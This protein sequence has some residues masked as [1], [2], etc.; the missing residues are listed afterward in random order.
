MNQL[1]PRN[2]FFHWSSKRVESINPRSYI[3]EIDFKPNGFWFDVDKDWE[4][5]C[6]GDDWNLDGLKY[7]YRVQLKDTGNILVLNGTLDLRKFTE[8]YKASKY[9]GVPYS[10]IPMD[11]SWIDWRKVAALYSGIIIAPYIWGCRTDLRWYYTW[12]C[13]SGCV[14]NL[15]NLDIAFLEYIER[16]KETTNEPT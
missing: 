14:W 8:E 1:S 6:I 2:E 16:K 4:R 3:Q 7:L 5:F 15:D 9:P 12:D 13:A 11:S 10:Y